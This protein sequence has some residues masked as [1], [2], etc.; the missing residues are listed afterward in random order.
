MFVVSYI[1]GSENVDFHV[2]SFVRLRLKI[3]N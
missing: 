3:W 1:L 2:T